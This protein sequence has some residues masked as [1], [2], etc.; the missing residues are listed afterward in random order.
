MPT[1]AD[2]A[3]RCPVIG[4]HSIDDPEPKYGMAVT[5][6]AHPDRL[7]RN[8]DLALYQA[9]LRKD[10]YEVFSQAMHSGAVGRVEME[11]ELRDALRHLQRM[12]EPTVVLE[13]EG[14]DRDVVGYARDG[15]D[16][17]RRPARTGARRPGARAVRL[18]APPARWRPARSP[19]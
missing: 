15:D 17:S 16:V 18:R 1:G 3:V 11:R 19:G 10:S 4:G 8:A 14:G 12:Q 7:L 13:L 6:V 9:K 2:R 5:G